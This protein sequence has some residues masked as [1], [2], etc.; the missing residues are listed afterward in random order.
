MKY[1]E[2]YK[3]FIY[4]FSDDEPAINAIAAEN[5][6]DDEDGMHIAFGMVVLPFLSRL[7][8][9]DQTA[10]IEKA[11]AYFEEMA[12]SDDHLISEVLEFTVIEGIIALGNDFVSKCISYMKPHTYDSFKAISQNFNQP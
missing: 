5:A 4:E 7:I 10:K 9:E 11:F 3:N 6:V 12:S 1:D 8:E 2:L